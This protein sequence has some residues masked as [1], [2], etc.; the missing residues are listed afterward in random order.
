MTSYPLY[1][2]EKLHAI[3]SRVE[4]FNSQYRKKHGYYLC[5]E[6]DTYVSIFLKGDDDLFIDLDCFNL[7]DNGFI[8]TLQLLDNLIEN[9]DATIKQLIEDD[10]RQ[11]M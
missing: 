5:F 2:I 4:C 1:K 3:L 11:G 8:T 9:R 7:D 10:K 6:Y